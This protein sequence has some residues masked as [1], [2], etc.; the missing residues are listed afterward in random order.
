MSWGNCE[1]NITDSH[2]DQSPKHLGSGGSC[3]LLDPYE[4]LNDREEESDTKDIS[5]TKT[6]N[7]CCLEALL[8]L[9]L[10]TDI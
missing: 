3:S 1:E 7:L 9:N 2:C 6:C 5:V 8:K 10:L 4:T